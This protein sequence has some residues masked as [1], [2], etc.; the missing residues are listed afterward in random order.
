MNVTHSTGYMFFIDLN[1]AFP[2][3]C[4]K[5]II[6][7]STKVIELFKTELLQNF[8][9]TIVSTIRERM[10]VKTFYDILIMKYINFEI[11]GQIYQTHQQL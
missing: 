4:H 6:S 5:K 2:F 7:N 1:T 3:I 8:V 9:V 10:N 11:N